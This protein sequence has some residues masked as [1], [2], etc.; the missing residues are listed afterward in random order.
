MKLALVGAAITAGGCIAVVDE[1]EPWLPADAVTGME[2]GPEPTLRASP[3][4]TLRIAS[5]N[6]HKLADPAA[7][8]AHLVA[9]T[10]LVAADVILVQETSAWPGEE[11]SRT[12][13]LAAQL[14]MTWAHDPVALLPDGVMQGN[15][16]LSKEV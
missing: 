11:S 4:C 16:I 15:A 10:E 1:G 12:A 9:S 8:L 2:L 6:L 13:Q 5:W 3:G 14:A 7:V